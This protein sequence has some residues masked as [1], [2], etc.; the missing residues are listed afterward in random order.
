[1]ELKEARDAIQCLHVGATEIVSGSVDGHVRTYDLRMGELRSDYL[2][3][4]CFL[5]N[6]FPAALLTRT[7]TDP[8][9]S[10]VPTLDGQTLLVATLD[11]KVRLLDR[12]NGGVLNTFAGHVNGSYRTRACF[13]HAEA[14]V[15][16]GDEDGRIWAWDLVDVCSPPTCL[17]PLTPYR[18]LH[19]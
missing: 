16:A 17:T 13:G 5:F 3:R 7:Y 2:G 19:L 4:V 10:V 18:R 1:M 12:T 6:A 14:S 9:T 11:A 15:V 8:V